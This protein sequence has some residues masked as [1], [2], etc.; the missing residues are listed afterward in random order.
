VK[1]WFRTRWFWSA[2]IPLTVLIAGVL[3]LRHD[4]TN[5]MHPSLDK[6]AAVSLEQRWSHPEMLKIRELGDKAVPPLRRVLREKDSP[7]THFLLWVKSKWPG[8]TKY[9][10]F[11]IPD[12]NK[13]TER[14]WTA[15]QVLQTLG[16]AGRSAVPELIQVMA[17]KDG[18]D[19]NGGSMALWAVGVDAEVCDQLDEVLEKG[20]SSFGRSQIVMALGNVKP[21]S[22]R[23]LR[24]LTRALTDPY[25]GVP[26]YAAET[27]GRLGVASPAVISGLTNL[28]SSSTDDLTVITASVAL[29]ELEKD[30][31]SVTSRVFEVLE[32]QLL[33][34]RPPPVGGGTGGQGVDATEQIFLAAAGL[35][36]EAKLGAAEKAKA[37][38]LLESFCEKSGRIFVRMLLLPPMIELGLSR[39]KCI[40]VCSTG[41]RQEEAYYRI[42][43][44]QLL[45]AVGDKFSLD[46]IDLDTLVHDKEV[47][48]RVSGA[49]LHW[50]KNKQATAVV[51]VLIDALD[52]KKHQSYYYA[53]IL[54]TA[55]KALGE[56]G[57]PAHDAAD[58]LTAVTRDPNPTVAKLAAE[59]LAKVHK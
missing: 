35:F 34:P 16:P 37:L 22:A 30:S 13:L 2:L 26:K 20:T 17:S 25:P 47:G 28:L 31:R 3:F 5:V 1:S 52:R 21:P 27:L 29:W 23:T 41:L 55:L 11:I 40:D 46:G 10:P 51:P 18:F 36:A 53:E 14:R 45:T 49:L 24:A 15:C 38:T 32:K 19:V 59:A 4:V 33:L 39:E 8:V 54:P 7:T 50:R 48:V 12:A 58:S 44:A 6:L 56:I 43:A 9:C 42:Q 57:P